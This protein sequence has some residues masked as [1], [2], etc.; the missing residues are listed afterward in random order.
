MVMKLSE[1]GRSIVKIA[2]YLDPRTVARSDI[3]KLFGVGVTATSMSVAINNAEAQETITQSTNSTIQLTAAQVAELT[4]KPVASTQD[5]E[6]TGKE[7]SE[8]KTFTIELPAQEEKI[9]NDKIVVDPEVL[10]NHPY[11]TVTTLERPPKNISSVIVLTRPDGLLMIES[12]EH[13]HE[14]GAL[15]QMGDSSREALEQQM[16]EREQQ[17]ASGQ[18]T[19][20]PQ[21]GPD[22]QPGR[23]GGAM[24]QIGPST[25]LVTC[26]H[27]TTGTSKAFED[28][29]I[30]NASGDISV[31]HGF[32]VQACP[33][34]QYNPPIAKV[35]PD[36]I[37]DANLAG[38]SVTVTGLGTDMYQ[39][40]G[41]VMAITCIVD[42]PS[43]KIYCDRFAIKLPV[44]E[45]EYQEMFKGMSG[46]PVIDDKTGT[47]VGMMCA[48]GEHKL[49]DGSTCLL[50]YMTG[51]NNFRTAISVARKQWETQSQ[52]ARI[53]PFDMQ[54]YIQKKVVE[55]QKQEALGPAPDYDPRDGPRIVPPGNNENQSS[56]EKRDGSTPAQPQLVPPRTDK[57]NKEEK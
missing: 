25:A 32:H 54:A 7:Q 41:K 23:G 21:V 9:H 46:Q 22:I 51:P 49:P 19:A 57:V 48:G 1:I 37:N 45:V 53:A 12:F 18:P 55:K 40:S 16:T 2:Q 14:T 29:T 30:R 6:K 35:A 11:G 34:D 38:R 36:T 28:E 42:S 33:N 39:I 10:A 27:V 3:A 43:G 24:V 13:L 4:G 8:V 47:V 5:Q 15:K 31:V 50:V 20:A 44:C 26:M 52:I 17:K 56:E